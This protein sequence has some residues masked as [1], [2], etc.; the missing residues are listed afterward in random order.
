MSHIRDDK[1]NTDK[2]DKRN[3]TLMR[4]KTGKSKEKCCKFSFQGFLDNFETDEKENVVPTVEVGVKGNM[5][6]LVP[7]TNV[8][9]GQDTHRGSLGDT[10]SNDIRKLWLNQPNTDDFTDD[11]SDGDTTHG[12]FSIIKIE[13]EHKIISKTIEHAKQ[14]NVKSSMLSQAK[15]K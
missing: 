12:L 4:E 9:V 7:T 3:E 13:E 14:D 2:Q 10:L 6:T 5:I 1:G 11:R 15:G 8:V